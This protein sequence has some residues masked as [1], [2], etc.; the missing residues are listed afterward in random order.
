MQN[1]GAL[2]RE[3]AKLYLEHSRSTSLRLLRRLLKDEVCPGEL[4][5]TLM[6]RSAA[7]P[8]VSTVRPRDPR[9]KLFSLR[10]Q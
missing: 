7:T 3:N 4:C 5:Q 6:V 10:S 1:L 9:L 2:R 8:R